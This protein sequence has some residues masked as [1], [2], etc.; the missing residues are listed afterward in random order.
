MATDKLYNYTIMYRVDG[1]TSGSILKKEI[2]CTSIR[3]LAK[4][5]NDFRA[6]NPQYL[7]LVAYLSDEEGRLVKA[8]KFLT[9][10]Y[11][12]QKWLTGY[13]ER[14]LATAKEQGIE[15]SWNHGLKPVHTHKWGG[16]NIG[17]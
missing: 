4:F 17:G 14:L 15:L 10:E 2:R 7:I 1:V 8:V 9:I 11:Q 12:A 6:R 16:V 3:S 13:N 5:L